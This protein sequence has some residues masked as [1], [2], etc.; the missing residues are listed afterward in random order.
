[1]LEYLH[2]Y[3]YITTKY[4]VLT[5]YLKYQLLRTIVGDY[6]INAKAQMTNQGASMRAKS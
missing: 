1:M 3:I 4:S 5:I 2:G 6:L